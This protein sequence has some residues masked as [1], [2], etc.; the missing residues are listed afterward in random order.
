MGWVIPVFYIQLLL[1]AILAAKSNFACVKRGNAWRWAAFINSLIICAVFAGI[2]FDFVFDDLKLEASTGAEQAVLGWL[3]IV[4]GFLIACLGS[5]ISFTG[6]KRTEDNQKTVSKI[7][8][9]IQS[10]EMYCIN[11]TSVASQ[12]A[13]FCKQCGT[14]IAPTSKP[15]GKPT[16]VG[17]GFQDRNT[18]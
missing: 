12:D 18:S 16:P 1:A 8:Q 4:G 7:T 3:C 2:G 5:W 15:R 6:N 14:Q 9:E 10:I 11:C 13:T 17:A